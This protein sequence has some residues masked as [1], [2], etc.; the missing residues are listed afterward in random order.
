M[1]ILILMIWFYVPLVVACLAVCWSYGILKTLYDKIKTESL[2]EGIRCKEDLLYLHYRFYYRVVME[3]L[4]RK[5][6]RVKR[7]DQCGE[8]DNG[9]ILNNIQYCE[10]WKDALGGMTDVEAA[11]KLYNRM[12]N[13]GIQRG[14]IVT[15]GEFRGNT[16][17]YCRAQV[18]SCI[19]GDELLKMCKEVQRRKPVY[20][21][22]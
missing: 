18:I 3:I 17:Y 11:M 10:I 16:R 12:L 5:G 14:M 9:L 20:L 4:R 8:D 7:T 15:L 6:Y 21:S 19:N 13:N 1:E 2:L 22:D